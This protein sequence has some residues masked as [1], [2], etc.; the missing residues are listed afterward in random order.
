MDRARGGGRK[1]GQQG[2]RL[3]LVDR[4][5]GDQAAS[6]PFGAAIRGAVWPI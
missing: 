3:D 6:W 1:T 2:T 5:D 4:S